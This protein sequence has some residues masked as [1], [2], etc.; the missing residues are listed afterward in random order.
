MSIW[1]IDAL[2][3]LTSVSYHY[4]CKQWDQRVEKELPPSHTFC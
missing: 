3:S 4:F 2:E 1:G